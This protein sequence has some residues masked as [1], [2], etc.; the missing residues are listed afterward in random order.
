MKKFVLACALAL[1]L[2]CLVDHRA[3]AWTNINFNAGVNF[4]WQ[5]GGDR[6]LL[7]GAYQSHD[8]TGYGYPAYDGYSYPP[9]SY[10]VPTAPATP[11]IQSTPA[12][13]PTPKPV[14][15]GK[16]T[17]YYNGYSN[18]YQPVGYYSGYQAPGAYYYSSSG[19]GYYQAPSYWYGR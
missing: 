7:W 15:D 19:Y 8:G 10:A 9:S 16:K 12:F 11:A 1:S 6:C 17:S 13:P 4:S 5:S 18:G 2:L 3:S 14:D